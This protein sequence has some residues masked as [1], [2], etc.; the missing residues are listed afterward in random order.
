[1]IKKEPSGWYVCLTVASSLEVELRTVK[2]EIK[3][4][5]DED[6]KADLKQQV[7][8]LETALYIH[9][10]HKAGIKKSDKAVGIDPGVKA[11]IA[12]DKGTLIK[13]NAKAE[14]REKRIQRLQRK[15]SRQT[16]HGKNF[17]KTSQQL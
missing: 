13:P 7:N 17:K 12:T 6:T 16:K 5:K 2:K 8:Q 9:E 15:L 4:T 11:L 3:S 10:S 14:K 1:V